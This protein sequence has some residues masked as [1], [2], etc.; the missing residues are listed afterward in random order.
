MGDTKREG[1]IEAHSIYR[2]ASGLL[3]KLGLI[4]LHFLATD[5]WLCASHVSCGGSGKGWVMEQCVIQSHPPIDTVSPPVVCK[6]SKQNNFC[7]TRFCGYVIICKQC[8]YLRH[9]SVFQWEGPISMV[10]WRVLMSSWYGNWGMLFCVGGE[11][12]KC[13]F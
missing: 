8:L 13:L 2:L 3:I 5:N 7:Q 11:K 4:G 9:K 1:S 12:W 10:V 6:W